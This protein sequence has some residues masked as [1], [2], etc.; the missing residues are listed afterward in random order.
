VNAR[1]QRARR[2]PKQNLRISIF[3]QSGY[4]KSWFAKHQVLPK[5]DRIIVVDPMAEYASYCGSVVDSPGSAK[6]WL[7]QRGAGHRDVPF[8][9]SCVPRGKD[10]VMDYLTLAWTL[11]DSLVVAEEV[12]QYSSAGHCPAPLRQLIQRGRHRRI[13]VCSISQR[14]A[15]CPVDVR[16]QADVTVVFRLSEDA[17]FEAMKKRLTEHASDLALLSVGR[18]RFVANRDVA[19]R[20][21]LTGAL[22]IGRWS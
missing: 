15:G 7:V 5:F 2:R 3:G 16:A 11:P 20:Y 4:G 8:R 10:D 21:G 13:S 1:V 9:L 6:R 18:H 22:D 17:D 14:P 19:K 12:S